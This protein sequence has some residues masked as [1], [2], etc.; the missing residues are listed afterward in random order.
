MSHFTPVPHFV[1]GS[2]ALIAFWDRIEN[3]AAIH[4]HWIF[5]WLVQQFFCLALSN[6]RTPG[7]QFVRNT[8]AE[9]T[10]RQSDRQTRTV[11]RTSTRR[12]DVMWLVAMECATMTAE[13]AKCGH[14][15]AER[16]EQ[17]KRPIFE[18]ESKLN[19][20]SQSKLQR[21]IWRDAQVVYI[22]IK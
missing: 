12:D 2:L 1:P 20:S 9:R 3:V 10:E 19:C 8:W 22:E 21:R 15:K 4:W 11:R 13:E 14:T 17:R 16:W 5:S 18:V 6:E 7:Q